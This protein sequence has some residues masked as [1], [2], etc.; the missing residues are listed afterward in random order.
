[1]HLTGT[2]LHHSVPLCVIRYPFASFG[3]RD[4]ALGFE[5]FDEPRVG[6]PLAL[7]NTLPKINDESLEN[8]L[9]LQQRQPSLTT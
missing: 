2:P 1:V 5:K 3:T 4:L 6:V 7:R 8:V 9:T